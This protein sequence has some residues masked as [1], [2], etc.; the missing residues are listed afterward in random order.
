HADARAQLR[1]VGPGI[2]HGGA[3]DGNGALLERLEGV[4]AL[5]ER[6]FP[7][8]RGAA[9]DDHFARGDFRGAVREHLEAAVPLVDVLDRDH[10]MMAILSW[11]RLTMRDSEYE[12][13]K[14]TTATKL[15]IS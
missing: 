14:Y 8:S 15:Y 5:D 2:P 3:V 1:Q 4:H 13:T 12:M 11:R 7:A 6:G 10:R 9:H